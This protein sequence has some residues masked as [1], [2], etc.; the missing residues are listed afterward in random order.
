[1][2]PTDWHLA[3]TRRGIAAIV[4]M[5]AF[6]VLG[7][8][9]QANSTQRLDYPRECEVSTNCAKYVG[10]NVTTT[11]SVVPTGAGPLQLKGV[12]STSTIL[13]SAAV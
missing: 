2:Y 3:C 10:Q 5:C 9:Y 11:G 8:Y 13:S 1:M 7:A 12:K 4:L 6:V